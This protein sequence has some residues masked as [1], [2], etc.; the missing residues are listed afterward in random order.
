MAKK[1]KPS[2]TCKI[3][4]GLGV[5]SV[6]DFV[7]L[8]SKYKLV[9]EKGIQYVN[10]N[11]T[12]YPK[13]A[14]LVVFSGVRELFRYHKS[15][16]ETQVLV[17][18]EIPTVLK[19][20]KD[21]V[22]LD[23]DQQRSFEFNFKEVDP[24]TVLLALRSKTVRI[25]SEFTSYDNLGYHVERVKNTGDFIASYIALTSNLPFNV[26]TSIRRLLQ[27]FF[28]AKK[29]HA[30]T[31]ISGVKDLCQDY[32]VKSEIQ[33]FAELFSE[34]AEAYHAAINHAG[35][36]ASVSKQYEV[37]QYAVAYLKKMIRSFTIVDERNRKSNVRVNV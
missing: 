25:T 21:I 13:K 6:S 10:A 23:Y 26:R 22:P 27:K 32:S 9:K 16:R 19:E 5:T 3:I 1:E 29:P 35:N 17:V 18:S 7:A 12:I 20:V 36:I 30:D 28:Q 11:T 8:M 34:Q 37:D 15:I 33:R 4:F 24:H 2:F 31:V 14:G